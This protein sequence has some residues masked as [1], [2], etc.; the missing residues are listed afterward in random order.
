MQSHCMYTG[1]SE[2]KAI[3]RDTRLINV[4]LN[5]FQV[6]S[7]VQCVTRCLSKSVNGCTA[8]QYDANSRQCCWILDRYSPYI[9]AVPSA[10][11]SVW[12]V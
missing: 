2:I 8:L 7:N 6:L 1:A 10:G 11:F 3:Y 5:C 12:T 9:Q 4:T